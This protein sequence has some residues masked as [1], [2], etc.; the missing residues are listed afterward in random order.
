M[1]A[2]GVEPASAD[3]SGR[4]TTCV[5]HYW[6]SPL[7]VSGQPLRGQLPG[8]SLTAA[9]AKTM[10]QSEL[11]TPHE[12]PRTGNSWNG[13]VSLRGQ[14]QISVGSYRK[15]PRFIE[16]SGT[17]ARSSTFTKHVE[18]GTPPMTSGSVKQPSTTVVW[19]LP[20]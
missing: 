1:E 20:C 3:G 17:S 18:T 8:F 2:A 4:G 15:F 16:V 6:L 7:V 12:P 11:S 5:D 19:K 9:A 13:P 14:R 10:S